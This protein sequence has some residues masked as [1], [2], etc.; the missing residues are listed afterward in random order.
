MAMGLSLHIGLNSVDPKHYQ[1]WSGDLA[2]CEF[3]AKDMTDIAKKRGFKPERLLTKNATASAVTAWLTDASKK[4]GKGD[5]LLLTYSG[6][7]GQVRDRNFDEDDDYDETWV[8]YDRQLVDDELYALYRRFAKGVRVLV[9]SDSCHS[10]TVVR[11]VP[12]FIDGGER[13]RAMP[14]S[15]GKKVESA[16]DA[17]YRDIQ[18]KSPATEESDLDAHVLL[19]SGCQ[20]N[21]YSRDGDRNGAF[22]GQLR[23]VWKN[24]DFHGRYR[25]FRNQIAARLPSDQSPNYFWAGARSTTFERQMPFT[26]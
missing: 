14:R 2:A 13:V 5:M 3:D 22:T 15:V 12:D 17:L 24:G 6:H 25:S 20:D 26:I 11:N 1:G 9:L 10:G 18:A 21:Q 19:I 16:N 8:L 23:K 7:G 4:L